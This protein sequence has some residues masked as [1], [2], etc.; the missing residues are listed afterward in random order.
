MDGCAG[1]PQTPWTWLE[2]DYGEWFK[3]AND[4]TVIGGGELSFWDF[5]GGDVDVE[6]L[7]RFFLNA[8]E[9][10]PY[11]LQEAKVY[12]QSYDAVLALLNKEQ[13]DHSITKDREQQLKEAYMKIIKYMPRHVQECYGFD[14]F[15]STLY[16]DTPAPKE[17]E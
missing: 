5:T 14:T 2:N 1:L 4:K 13:V 7:F 12:K 10:L 6:K 15:L 8:P 9:A 16:P 17:G 3:D 11:W